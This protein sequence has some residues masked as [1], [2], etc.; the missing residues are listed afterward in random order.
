L[1]FSF[2]CAAHECV[3]R[4]YAPSGP[5]NRVVG[6][7]WLTPLLLN[8]PVHEQVHLKHHRYTGT[9]DD[10]EFMPQLRY[11]AHGMDYIRSIVARITILKPIYFMNW[12]FAWQALLGRPSE[13]LG[14]VSLIRDGRLVSLI[15][16][17]WGGAFC[18]ATA[19]NPWPMIASYWIPVL[20]FGPAAGLFFSQHEHY[21][22][23]HH[24]GAEANTSTMETNSF[25]Q[26]L[27]WNINHHTAHHLCPVIPFHNLPT[28]TA[29]VQNNILHR[30]RSFFAFHKQ[31]LR[32][33]PV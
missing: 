25:I 21:M 19:V 24:R 14:T 27:I 15:L 13:F 4:T 17:V 12:R 2:S 26:F 31:L 23:D 1:L 7:L 10:P 18:A 29:L 32:G 30:R 9:T 16:L 33:R 6:T 20:I 22:V 3:H 5:V 28:L 11:Y 8:Y